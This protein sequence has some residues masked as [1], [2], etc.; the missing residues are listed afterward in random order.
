MKFAIR[1]PRQLFSRQSLG[2]DFKTGLVLGVEGVP[3]NLSSGVLAA[4]NPVAAVYAGIFGIAGAALFSSSVLMPV[5]ATGALSIIVRDVDLAATDDPAGGL[6]MLTL[7][8]GL[9]M[10][11]AGVVRAGRVVRFVSDSVV[12]GFIA[13]VGV[14]IIL[15]QFADI[16]RYEAEG[17]RIAKS[18]ETL[19]HLLDWEWAPVLVGVVTAVAI[20]VL[21]RT[22]LGGMGY[23]VAIVIAWVI[24]FVMNRNGTSVQVV[25][26]IADVPSGL[27][28][29]ILPDFGQM[30]DLAVPALSLAFVGLVQGA[31]V[32]SSVENPD[33]SQIDASQDFVAQGVGN[34]ASGVFRGMPVG[35]SASGTVLMQTAG[36]KSRGALLFT[37]I[38]MAV[39][40]VALAPLV[41][42][43]PLSGLAGM[44][45]IIGVDTIPI[46]RVRRVLL[47]GTMPIAVMA[48]TFVLTMLIPLQFAVLAGV[49][50]SVLLFVVGESQR[51]DLKRII[52]D[53]D[54]T[55]REIDPPAE[56]GDHEIVVIQPYGTLFFASAE[57]LVA[58]LPQITAASNRSVVILRL[59]GEQTPSAT[60]VADLAGYDDDLHDANCRFVV[61]TTSDDLV[62]NLRSAEAL[63]HP[64]ERG[65]YRGSDRL[66]ATVRQAVSDARVWIDQPI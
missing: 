20:V 18:I 44:L 10:L 5:Q 35:G 11:I 46:A 23:V 4:V 38:V 56:L 13:A 34:L 40:I 36:A 17:N 57:A 19:I 37:S 14:N 66:G 52:V 48:I 2:A 7:L 24:A 33:G 62:N 63:D 25:G 12:T 43:V 8:A 53:D 32:A 61:V 54:G 47:T 9:V 27:P 31:G 26:D 21:R 16:T 55:L 42:E 41:A 39:L 3:D 22:V 28:G 45:V 59:R 1:H 30:L 58:Q 6:A 51:L 60:L 15:G 49:G 64:G 65:V 29:P 50:I